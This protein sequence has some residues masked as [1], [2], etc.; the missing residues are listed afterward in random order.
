MMASTSTRFLMKFALLGCTFGVGCGD[1]ESSTNISGNQVV[2]TDPV[3]RGTMR[4]DQQPVEFTR[5]TQGRLE[6]GQQVRVRIRVDRPG[7][8]R[9]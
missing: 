6:F 8:Q 2:N 7:W 5:L 1:D 9:T 4:S 3:D